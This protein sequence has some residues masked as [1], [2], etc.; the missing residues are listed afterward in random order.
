MCRNML[1]TAA[2][3][4]ARRERRNA[5]RRGKAGRRGGVGLTQGR[6]IAEES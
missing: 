5:R 1:L 6:V 4:P 2:A 3:R